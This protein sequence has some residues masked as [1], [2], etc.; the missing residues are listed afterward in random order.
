MGTS[1]SESPSPSPSAT[2]F[3]KK[4]WQALQKPK[5]HVFSASDR[6]P[7]IN[8]RNTTTPAREPFI[9]STG[10]PPSPL[11]EHMCLFEAFAAGKTPR[12]LQN[13]SITHNKYPLTIRCSSNADSTTQCA[14]TLAIQELL[15]TGNR[16]RP[17]KLADRQSRSTGTSTPSSAG[18]EPSTG[19]QRACTKTARPQCPGT[20]G[21][22]SAQRFRCW[23]CCGRPVRHPCRPLSQTTLT[24][25][26]FEMQD[27]KFLD[28]ICKGRHHPTR[29]ENPE[30]QS[31]RH[32]SVV[33][34]S[35]R[36]QIQHHRP[37]QRLECQDRRT[38][39]EGLVASNCALNTTSGRTHVQTS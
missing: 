10:T 12:A 25:N 22:A 1:N 16:S 32:A 28:L 18:S 35:A 4:V 21:R 6:R 30:K 17:D 20:L 38:A 2:F 33:C 7:L 19:R 39:L 37:P 8:S 11:T 31:T 14:T 27:T 36:R 24:V 9:P 13:T 23:P 5:L 3:S 34:S 15:N 26:I 29:Q